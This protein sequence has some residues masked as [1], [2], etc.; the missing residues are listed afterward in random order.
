MILKWLTHPL[1]R[2]KDFND[3]HTSILRLQI[4]QEKPFLQKIYEEWYTSEIAAL[5][6]DREPILEIGSGP[7]F[8]D[9][10]L[11]DLITSDILLLPNVRLV[12][13]GRRL[14]F[15]DQTLGSIVLTDVLHHISRPYDFLLEAARCVRPKGVLVM[16]EPWVTPWS[17][18]IYKWLHHEPFEP[19]IQKW[20]FPTNGPLSGANSAIP[21]ILF[22]R[23]KERFEREFPTWH[24]RTI[25]L[26]VPFRY[27]LS[28]G[29]S[30]WFSMPGWSFPIWRV[31]EQV[32]SPWMESLAMF[33][34]IVL[35]RT[36]VVR[37]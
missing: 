35:E 5:P 24:I 18:F 26:G 10:Y 31:L 34:L 4:I 16:H 7:G 29:I 23:D 3:P 27:I 1:I 9:R 32:L 30:Y 20:E 17:R 6:N 21:W 13:D 15:S 25:Q 14:P 22:E 12:L 11:P 19:N 33:A 37:S 8:L 36:H 28:G 2:G